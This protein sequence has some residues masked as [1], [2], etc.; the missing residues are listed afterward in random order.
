MIR[1]KSRSLRRFSLRF[2]ACLKLETQQI[3]RK[4][5]LLR[6]LALRY[7][8]FRQVQVPTQLTH[9][10]GFVRHC[11]QDLEAALGENDEKLIGTLIALFLQ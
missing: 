1:P 9:H 6:A 10:Y 5:P 11:A 4:V 8:A 7:Y 3:S 2:K